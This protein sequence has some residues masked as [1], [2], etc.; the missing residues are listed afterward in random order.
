MPEGRSTK[1]TKQMGIDDR[2]VGA[3]SKRQGQA[4]ERAEA[5]DQAQD[6]PNKADDQTHTEAGSQA[7][8]PGNEKWSRIP[9]DEVECLA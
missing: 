2:D 7:Q 6:R 8:P 1:L 9:G 4:E 3:S 5:R